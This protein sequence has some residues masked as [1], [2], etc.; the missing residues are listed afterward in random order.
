MTVTPNARRPRIEAGPAGT[1]RVAVTAPAR[2]GRANAALIDLLADHFGVP[3]SKIHILQGASSR[4]K[5][6]EVWG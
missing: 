1:L 4:H 5:V 6:V 3:P 2:E